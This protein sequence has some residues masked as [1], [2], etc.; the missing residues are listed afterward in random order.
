MVC[1]C[2]P[3]IIIISGSYYVGY[4]HESASAADCRGVI[5][6]EDVRSL[7]RTKGFPVMI[8]TYPAPDH[9]R[10]DWRP[11]SSRRPRD[12][13]YMHRE[14]HEHIRPPLFY[15]P[16]LTDEIIVPYT[17]DEINVRL[18]AIPNFQRMVP[19][20]LRESIGDFLNAETTERR[21]KGWL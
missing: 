5:Y 20:E 19:D 14:H 11:E 17:M 1:L 3:H 18:D 15:M 9:I 8:I 21:W 10:Y 7:A 2:Q 13:E 4:I 6:V 12:A 16:P